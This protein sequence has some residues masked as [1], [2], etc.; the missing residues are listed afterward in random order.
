M[1]T[2]RLRA[3]T[4]VELLV[5]IAIIGILIALLLPAV[6]AAR[7]AARRTQCVN[8]LKQLALGCHNYHDVHKTFPP[9]YIRGTGNDPAASANHE[10]WGWHAFILPFVEQQPLHELLGVNQ[11]ELEHVCAGLN[12]N[13]PNPVATLQTWI[14]CFV[15]PSDT[16]RVSPDNIADS[17]RHFGGG[18][19][20]AAGGL[21]NWRPGITNYIGNRGVRDGIQNTNDCFGIF[22]YDSS[23]S[24]KSI[25]DG[26]TNT[27]MI[28]ERDTMNCRSGTWIGVRNPNGE[29]SRG[30]WYNIG[31]TRTV[32]NAPV[33][34][35][36]WDSNDGCGESFSS[37]HPGGANFALCD[38]SVRFISENIEFVDS[39]VGGYCVWDNFSPG[40]P[41]YAWYY[42]Y[43]KLSRRNDG[44]PVGAY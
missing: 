39:C 12:P 31:H 1:R 38:A 3:F 16:E 19:G 18:V 33:T 36:A 20:T 14:S 26:T 21:G 6:Q 9:G 35:F 28:G 40:D 8:N 24:I 22:F 17:D 10:K 4:L 7:E 37:F 11:M 43:N 5:V 15:C 44:F 25:R 2:D 30:I 23:V 32:L 13:V 29:G 41:N 42:T 34:V 27:L